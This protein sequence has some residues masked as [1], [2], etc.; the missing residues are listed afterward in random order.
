[1]QKIVVTVRVRMCVLVCVCVGTRVRVK[2]IRRRSLTIRKQCNVLR[3]RV[4][5]YL[6]VKSCFELHVYGEET[7]TGNTD[8]VRHLKWIRYATGINV[9]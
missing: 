2:Q 6:V 8:L 3:E 7:F 4:H 9:I 1:M 5:A